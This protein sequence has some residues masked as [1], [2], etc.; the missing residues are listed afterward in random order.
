MPDVMVTAL[1]KSDGTMRP[2]VRCVV[3]LPT[4]HSK[5]KE[6]TYPCR[7]GIGELGLHMGDVVATRR[8]R[9][10]NGGVGDG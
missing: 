1:C 5:Q 8:E 2:A 3:L 9:R 10:Q 4:C 7:K 6:G